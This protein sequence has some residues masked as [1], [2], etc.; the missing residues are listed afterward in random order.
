MG[1]ADLPTYRYAKAAS[2]RTPKEVFARTTADSNGNGEK[3]NGEGGHAHAGEEG[4]EEEEE[5]EGKEGWQHES[6]D[7]SDAERFSGSS[8]YGWAGDK[9]DEEEE[10]ESKGVE[11]EGESLT[12]YIT[13]L[14]GGRR[15]QL[16]QVSGAF[17]GCAE[18]FGGFDWLLRA[19]AEEEDAGGCP[20]Q[21][22]RRRP[23]DGSGKGRGWWGSA[24]VPHSTGRRRGARLLPA[25]L[26][27]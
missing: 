27:P 1:W 20:H 10:G 17:D 25:Q 8:Y 15:W 5:E 19:I 9:S 2:P 24:Q 4:E 3:S 7:S 18:V 13:Y 16:R 23:A 12:A 26:R 21:Q 11:E 14:F 22:Q 6:G